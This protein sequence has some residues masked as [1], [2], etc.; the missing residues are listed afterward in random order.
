MIIH[1][2]NLAQKET[3]SSD[4]IGRYTMSHYDDVWLLF[5]Y[6]FL[7]CSV[8]S[9]SWYHSF[10]VNISNQQITQHYPH[11]TYKKMISKHIS[12]PKS[13][14]LGIE[15]QFYIQNYSHYTKLTLFLETPKVKIWQVIFNKCW[16]I[17]WAWKITFL[18]SHSNFH[19]PWDL[20]MYVSSWRHCT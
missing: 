14:N 2:K 3:T 5:I 1:R 8:F 15:T 6:C 17:H 12:W 20:A 13:M 18:L 7:L 9:D 16:S 10:L 11:L 4:K 19:H